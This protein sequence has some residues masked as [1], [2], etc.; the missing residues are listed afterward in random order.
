MRY[1]SLS[2]IA[3]AVSCGRYEVKLN[4]NT[5][6]TPPPVIVADLADAALRDCI[7]QALATTSTLAVNLTTLSC[8]NAGVRSLTGLS[9]F[10]RLK[11]LNLAGN[12]L[13]ELMELASLPALRE[14]DLSGNPSLPCAELEALPASIVVT[15]PAHC[16]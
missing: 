16:R 11:S 15:S 1:L 7:T 6:Y 13:R 12:D 3:L 2:L 14:V 9:A 8:P 10:E 4:D 5:V